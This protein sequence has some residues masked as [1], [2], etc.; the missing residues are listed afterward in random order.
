MEEY[1]ER[2]LKCLINLWRTRM[3]IKEEFPLFFKEI[4]KLVSVNTAVGSVEC[5]EAVNKVRKK[6]GLG[7]IIGS[8]SMLRTMAELEIAIKEA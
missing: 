1:K 7:I 3:S 6:Y 8:D 2:E 4:M 5:L